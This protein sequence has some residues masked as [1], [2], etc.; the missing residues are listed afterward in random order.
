MKSAFIITALLSLFVCNTQAQNG[1][2]RL[3]KRIKLTEASVEQ[4]VEIEVPEAAK[5]LVLSIICTIESGSVE[6]VL[7]DPNGKDMGKIKLGSADGKNSQAEEGKL[8]LVLPN[9]ANGTWKI[10]VIPKKVEGYLV[11][12]ATITLETA[13]D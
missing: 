2:L 10:K 13:N 6:V 7:Y 5:T 1:S 3:D 12:N 8:N 4:V 9:A 11:S